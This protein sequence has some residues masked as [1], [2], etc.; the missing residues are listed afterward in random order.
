MLYNH[1]IPHPILVQFLFPQQLGINMSSRVEYYH[2]QI[3]ARL[4]STKLKLDQ[5]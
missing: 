1:Y 5:V 3:R 4:L 2:D